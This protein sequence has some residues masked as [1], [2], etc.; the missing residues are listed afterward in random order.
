[1]RILNGLMLVGGSLF[2]ARCYV[3]IGET[4][5]YPATGNKALLIVLAR[6]LGH[7]GTWF[8]NKL[9]RFYCWSLIERL[10]VLNDF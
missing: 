5:A 6:P 3:I 8:N 2:N 1:M 7:I 4:V 10:L 9:T